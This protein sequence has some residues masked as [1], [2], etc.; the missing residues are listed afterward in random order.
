MSVVT[1][2]VVIP[3][4]PFLRSFSVE[5]LRVMDH[6]DRIGKNAVER[7]EILKRE[8]AQDQPS[9]LKNQ[10]NLPFEKECACRQCA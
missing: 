4:D 1:V 6:R 5:R 10:P 2:I 3:L 9:S 8:F 7:F